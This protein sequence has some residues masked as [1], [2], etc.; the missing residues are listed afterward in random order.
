[1]FYT[2]SYTYVYLGLS[3]VLVDEAGWRLETMTGTLCWSLVLGY[4]AG[5]EAGD[6]EWNSMLESDAWG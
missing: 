5:L 1:M 3:L 6:Y 4:E 2:F